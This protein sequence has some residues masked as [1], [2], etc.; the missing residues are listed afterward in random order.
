MAVRAST[1]RPRFDVE[2]AALLYRA[3][4]SCQEIAD[5]YGLTRSYVSA[6]LRRA[7]TAMRPA[8]RPS[9]E[10]HLDA[11]TVVRLRDVGATW[12]ELATIFRVSRYAVQRCYDRATGG[13]GRT[14]TG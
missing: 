5:R 1:R 11:D 14:S 2:D 3:G 12:T 9:D 4:A 6:R 8:S 13:S 7:G 10:H